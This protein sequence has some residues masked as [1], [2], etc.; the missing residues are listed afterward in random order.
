MIRSFKALHA[1]IHRTAL[2]SRNIRKLEA[3]VKLYG[4]LVE[5]Y[6]PA[7]KSLSSMLSHRF[8]KI[9][10]AVVEELWVRLETQD[11]VGDEEE[12]KKTG[13]EFK[14][15]E[16]LKGFDWIKAKKEEVQARWEVILQGI[17]MEEK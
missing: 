1:L 17:E 12:K 3:C 14:G 8:P 4:G 7:L 2:N 5:V 11:S 13:G 10:A 6:P 9:R 16:E 15:R